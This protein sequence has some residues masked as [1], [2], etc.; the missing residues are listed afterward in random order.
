M[1]IRRRIA[2]ASVA[3]LFLGVIAVGVARWQQGYRA[4]VIHTGSMTPT[5]VPGDLIIDRPAAPH[6]FPT[7]DIITFR[8]SARPDLVT[9]RITS[10]ADTGIHAKGDG[11][12]TADVW[13][14]SPRMVQ[15]VEQTRLPLLGYLAVYLKQPTGIASLATSVLGLF[16]LW[17]LFFPPEDPR[18]AA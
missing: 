5:L 16:P 4:Y 3:L 11:N 9:H 13:T 14:I 6:H 17:R 18:T 10:V 2:W 7:G 12:R 8:H 1:H 15:G